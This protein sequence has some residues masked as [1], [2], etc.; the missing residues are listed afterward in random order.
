MTPTIPMEYVYYP[1]KVYTLD[2]TTVAYIQYGQSITKITFDL[3][4]EVLSK[5]INYNR[6]DQDGEEEIYWIDYVDSSVINYVYNMAKKYD[7]SL[8][9]KGLEYVK[10]YYSTEDSSIEDFSLDMMNYLTQVLDY[11]H[12]LIEMHDETECSSYK[13]E[14]DEELIEEYFSVFADVKE[15][16]KD[17]KQI[18]NQILNNQI[19]YLNRLQKDSAVSH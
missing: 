13:I 11:Y 9:I 14:L 4:G 10:G 18:I 7:I 12:F 6:I 17:D 2:N 1:F 15:L 3:N 16:T 8:M 5:E 19:N